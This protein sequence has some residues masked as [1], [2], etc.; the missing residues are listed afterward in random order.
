M[1][2]PN[3]QLSSSFTDH[4]NELIKKEFL[5]NFR[6]K[7][8][9]APLG[10]AQTHP[11]NAG[12]V[13]RWL[14]IEDLVV[15]PDLSDHQLSEGVTPDGTNLS[16]SKVE[17]TLQQFGD[18]V[19]ISDKFRD[20][21]VGD[22]L[23]K[24]TDIIARQAAEVVDTV[25]RNELDLNGNDNFAQGAANKAAV[26][27]GSLELTSDDLKRI[28]SK[29]LRAQN[30]PTFDDSLYRGVLHPFMEFSIL[31]ETGASDYIILASN[32]TTGRAAIEMAEI[33]TSPVLGLRLLR[34]TQ[35][36][37][38]SVSTD[39]FANIFLGKDVFGTVRHEAQDIEVI[40]KPFGTSGTDDPLNQRATIAWKIFYASKILQSTGVQLMHAFGV[41]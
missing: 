29:K 35:I 41:A 11:R 28:V 26:Q 22:I 18:F 16:D 37:A 20:I 24:V 3:T 31:N 17:A 2:N 10:M 32:N 15:D 30:V 38:D 14:K 13:M 39:V 40:T 19:T 21:A 7:L 8:V 5:V 12:E 27:S 25:S 9:L 23:R 36:R 6:S 34:T 4:F 33:G 1:A